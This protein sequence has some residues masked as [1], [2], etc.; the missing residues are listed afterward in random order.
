VGAVGSV[1]VVAAAGYPAELGRIIRAAKDA[2]GWGLIA[3]LGDALALAAAHALDL[4][5]AAEPA[6]LVPV[7][8]RRRDPVA[9]IARRAALRLRTAG[10]PTQV[11]GWLRWRRSAVDQVGLSAAERRRNVAGA[12]RVA[13]AVAGRA[14]AAVLLVDD[15]VT[16]GATAGAAVDA[17]AGAGRRPLAVACIAHPGGG[18]WTGATGAHLR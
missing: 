4:A 17:L 3:P 16:T 5:V 11:C 9:A 8:V 10:R 15:L 1:P 12:F 14:D 6:V 13:G 18:L 7:P 2:G